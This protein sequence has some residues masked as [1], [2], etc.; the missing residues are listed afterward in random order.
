MNYLNPRTLTKI[1]FGTYVLF[2]IHLPIPHIGGTGLYLPFNII[3]W[4]FISFIIGLGSYQI[5]ISKKFHF[6]QFNMH[7]LIGFAMML[8]PFTY[9]N[10][11]YSNYAAM[12][13]FGLGMGILLLLAY[14]QFQF[15]GDDLYNFLFM[16][17]GCVLIQSLFKIT[18]QFIPNSN[19][20]G[21]LSMIHFGPMMQK[22]IFATYLST[23]ATI[24]L[25]LI[26]ID[27]SIADHRYKQVLVYAVP[28]MVLTQFFPLQSR[29]GYLSLFLGIGIILLIS[30]RSLKKTWAWL[31]IA[32]IGYM[33]GF[34]DREHSRSTEAIEYSGDSRKTTYLLTYELIRENPIF[35][36]GY[37]GFLHAFREHYAKR[38]KSDLSIHTIGNNNMDHPHNEILFWTVEGGILPLIGILIIAGSFLS[39]V[40]KTKKKKAWL[41]LCIL[42]PIVVH[43]QLELPFYISVIHWFT[44]IY[45]TYMMDEEYGKKYELRIS[46]PYFFR[47]LSVIVPTIVSIYMVT[48]L[49]TAML[50]TKF[51]RTGYRDPSI[52]VSITNPHAWQKKYETLIMNLSLRIAKQTRDEEKLIDYIEWAEKYVKHSPYLFIYYDLATAYESL[53]RREKA[54]EIY[55]YAQYLFPGAKWQEEE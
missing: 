40:W 34:T 27:D 23:G 5:F 22:N 46:H 7:C 12:R 30:F 3:A 50:I 51:E 32:S 52:L 45:I 1:V 20:A 28:L 16:I 13:M 33:V 9:N 53:N 44:F 41:L 47:G 8:I 10:N 2:A 4:I 26:L 21:I 15:D 18:E 48:T 54:W 11:A 6:S 14:K 49:Q 42:V 43:T 25:V 35:G 24:S 31:V 29:T 38:K 55:R 37:G 36:V 19:L 39:M 17:L